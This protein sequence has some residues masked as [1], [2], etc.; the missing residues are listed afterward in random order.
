MLK[1]GKM[2]HCWCWSDGQAPK[3]RYWWATP[4]IT[5]RNLTKWYWGEVVTEAPYGITPVSSISRTSKCLYNVESTILSFSRMLG[6]RG[7]HATRGCA[8]GP[9]SSSCRQRTARSQQ[10]LCHCDMYHLRRRRFTPSL[11]QSGRV[12]CRTLNRTAGSGPFRV[13]SLTKISTVQDGKGKHGEVPDYERI[14]R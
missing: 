13:M 3:G 5:L 12:P 1:P 6:G 7:R 2:P 11:P 4:A 9:S 14:R 8:S 10:P